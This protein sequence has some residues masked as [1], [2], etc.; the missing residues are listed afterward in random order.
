MLRRNYSIKYIRFKNLSPR[1][2]KLNFQMQA[3]CTEVFPAKNIQKQVHKLKVCF[4]IHTIDIP[5]F[6]YSRN[7]RLLLYMITM[8]IEQPILRKTI[9]PVNSKVVSKYAEHH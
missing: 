7:L 4:S 9:T 1:P 5:T 3:T 8:S 6:L 2:L